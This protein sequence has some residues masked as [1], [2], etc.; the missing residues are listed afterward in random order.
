[1]SWKFLG[2]G[3]KSLADKKKPIFYMMLT[4]L[5]MVLDIY[6]WLYM[7]VLLRETTCASAELRIDLWVYQRVHI[8]CDK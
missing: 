6:M 1:M 7:S 8:L 4:L 3:A 2:F 5:F